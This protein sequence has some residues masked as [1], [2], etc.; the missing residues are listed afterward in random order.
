M[1]LTDKWAWQLLALGPLI[2][3]TPTPQPL[4]SMTLMQLIRKNCT[5]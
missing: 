4:E 3:T 5:F 1:L 2:T